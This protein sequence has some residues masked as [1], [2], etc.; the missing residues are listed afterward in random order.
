[1]VRL[2]RGLQEGPQ[3]GGYEAGDTTVWAANGPTLSPMAPERSNS[4]HDP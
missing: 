1:M 3:R 2:L 4:I